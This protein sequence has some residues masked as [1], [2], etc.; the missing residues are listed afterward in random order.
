MLSL[1]LSAAF[2]HVPLHNQAA[3]YLSF[4]FALPLSFTDAEGVQRPTP[5]PPGAY[6]VD[7]Y[8]VVER[9]CRSLPFGFTNSPFTFT[10]VIKVIAKAMRSKGFKCLWFLDDCLVALPTR[11]QAMRARAAIEDLLERSGFTRAVDKGCFAVA[12][13]ILPDHLGFEIS[14]IGPRGGLR[15]PQRRCQDIARAARDLL[16]R[17]ARDKRRV[18]TELLR[19]F[20]GRATSVIAAVDMARFWLR[21]LHDVTE[22]FR[23]TST[24]DRAALRDL[25]RWAEFNVDSASNGRP[26]WPAPPSAAIYTD[27]SGSIGFGSVIEA[28]V[29]ARSQYGHLFER[30]NLPGAF[31]RDAAGGGQQRAGQARFSGGFWSPEERLLFHITLKELIAVRRGIIVHAQELRGRV[32]RLWEDNLAVVHII[33]NR[34]SKS[35]ALMAE[36][37]VLL[38]LLDEL[39]I[40]LRPRYIRS[41]LNPADFYS[42]LVDRDAWSLRP[43]VTKMILAQ[44]AWRHLP[45]AS[46]DPFASAQFAQCKRFASRI[47][48]P[49]ALASDGLALDWGRERGTVW[50]NPPWALLPACIAKLQQERP[51]AVLIVP[52]WPTQVWWPALVALGGHHLRLPRPKFSVVAHHGR[53]VEPF[54]NASIQLLAVLLPRGGRRYFDA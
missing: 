33:A 42:R 8:I 4:H 22:L 24:L 51:A 13:Q 31:A 54:L 30:P 20:L 52:E 14:T 28:P 32:V 29:E 53:K 43:S 11:A 25:Q 48:A 5:M 3:K 15:V 35:H 38:A 16:C 49:S 17:A 26:L 2:W 27:A 6:R 39:H 46:L 34:T 18:P 19:T 41:E 21:S 37:R 1:D 12:T 23:E 44:A 47:F 10:K 40:E 45:A 36:L 50:V 7:D 9:S